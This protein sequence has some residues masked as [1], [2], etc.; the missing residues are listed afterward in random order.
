[1]T[2]PIAL[3]PLSLKNR[4]DAFYSGCYGDHGVKYSVCI[5]ACGMMEDVAGPYAGTHHDQNLVYLS[6]LTNRLAQFCS[7]PE[8]NMDFMIYGDPAYEGSRFVHA[9]F[10]R[11]TAT[12]TERVH[13]TIMST[14]RIAVEQAIGSVTAV[15]PAMDFTRMERMGLE[16]L[17]KKYLVAVILRNLH[18]VIQGRNQISDYFGCSPPT[19]E[20][21]LAERDAPPP[22]LVDL[23]HFVE[24]D[25]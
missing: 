14:A 16:A 5:S 18:T 9:P 2:N 6:N 10:P 11:L 1:M 24:H 7:Y 25:H 13:N 21:W 3:H 15:F 17:G 12:P 19:M 23:G 20:E 4:Q 8:I 22:C